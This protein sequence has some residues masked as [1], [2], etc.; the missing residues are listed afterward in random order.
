MP[1]SK[2]QTNKTP[3]IYLHSK[4]ALLFTAAKKTLYMGNKRESQSMLGGL[5]GFGLM[6]DNFGEDSKKQRFALG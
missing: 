4:V 3:E 2:K 6:L 1:N 5:T